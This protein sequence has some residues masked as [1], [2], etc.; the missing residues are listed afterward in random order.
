VVAPI[1]FVVFAFSAYRAFGVRKGLAVGLYRNQALWA[2]T[3]AAY[4]ALLFVVYGIAF[5]IY[6]ANPGPN[7]TNIIDDFA[8]FA[9]LYAALILAFQ[10]VDSSVSVARRSDPLLRDTMHWKYTR[11]ALWLLILFGLVVS[12]SVYGLMVAIDANGDPLLAQVN[13]YI[14]NY[15]VFLIVGPLSFLALYAG[16]RHSGDPTL[17]RHLRWLAFYILV[18]LLQGSSSFLTRGLTFPESSSI[19]V[20]V[21]GVV[22]V[23]N[24]L[25]L[26]RTARSL[27]PLNRI[28]LD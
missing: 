9:W 26:Y 8:V 16:S 12:F 22:T 21:I 25:A 19:L 5:S 2:G 18:L 14:L 28:T 10:W 7:L 17:R 15:P 24:G 6:Q 27:A 3:T 13:F 20:V 4:W 11:I 23:A 1:A